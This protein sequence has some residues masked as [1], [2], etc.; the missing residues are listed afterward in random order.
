MPATDPPLSTHNPTS[1]TTRMSKN[2]IMDPRIREEEQKV[3]PDVP[4]RAN[5]MYIHNTWARTFNSR[6]EL[7]I[8]P[9]NLE[10]IQKLVKLARRCRRRVVLVGCGHSPSDITCTSSWMVNL[11][12]FQKVLNVD[13]EQKR[14]T[15]EAGIRLRQL[16]D[17]AAEYG[18]TMPNLGSINDQSIAGAIATATH[19][20]SL[21]HGLMSESVK[22]IKIVLGDGRAVKCSADEN[23]DL[24][25]AA[26]TSIGGL[27]ILVEVEF[28]LDDHTNIEWTQTLKPLDWVLSKWEKDLWTDK[29]FTRV[30]WLP[31]MK[32]AVVWSATKTDKPERA[33]ISSWYG[34]S[35]GFHTYHVLLW[36]SNKVPRILPFIEWFVFGMQYGFSD[37]VITTAIEPQRSGLLMNCLYSQF[38]NEWALPLEKGPEAITRLS[39]WLNR[40]EGHDIPFDNRGLYVHAPVEVRVS[41][42]SRTQPRPFLD[43]TNQNGPTLYLN[44]TLYRPFLQDPPCTHRYYEAFEWLMKELGAKPHWAKNFSFVDRNDIESMFGENLDAYLKVRNET[45]PDGVFIGAWHRRYILPASQPAFPC[46]EKELTRTKAANGGQNWF[47]NLTSHPRSDDEK[48][49]LLTSTYGRV[50]DDLNDKRTRDETAATGMMGTKVFDKM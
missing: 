40:E 37:D 14:L 34:G 22:S 38:V 49:D 41:D 26:L 24:F 3:D 27:G 33:P 9:H 19:G 12:N 35:V 25:R 50:H 29:E 46:E 13:R 11:D 5:T 21:R 30:W 48:D 6:P 1:I 45:D 32:R 15:V 8:Q 43:N 17:K 2:N 7:Y 36:L 16:N 4:F 44:A 39:R 18:L 28:Q 31:Y 23:V 20:S 10:E 42:T 47:G